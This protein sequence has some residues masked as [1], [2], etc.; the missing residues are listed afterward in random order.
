MTDV[1]PQKRQ[2]RRGRLFPGNIIP[3]EELAKRKAH[4][5]LFSKR[6]RVIFDKLLPELINK[7]YGWYIAIEPNSGDYFI[8]KDKET[9][10][11]KARQKYP[12]TIHHMYGI[13][14]TG[15]SGRI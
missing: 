7:Y 4:R 5:E 6:C 14:E 8:D 13:N 2:L 1:T 11:L 3:P 12:N 9:A 10:S 15:T